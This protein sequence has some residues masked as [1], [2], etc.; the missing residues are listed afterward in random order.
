M[1]PELEPPL[2]VLI[3]SGGHT[4]VAVMEDHGR[5]R[6]AG[7]TVDDAAGEAFDK[8][9]RFLG[10]GYPGGFAGFLVA[11]LAAASRRWRWRPVS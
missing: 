7:Q 6:I 5:Y 10:L 1:E 3:A 9:A 4:L 11:A 8:V 2:A